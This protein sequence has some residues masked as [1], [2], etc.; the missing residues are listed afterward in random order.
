[1]K[2]IILAIIVFLGIYTSVNAQSYQPLCYAASINSASPIDV[3]TSDHLTLSFWAGNNGFLPMDKLLVN[4]RM[5]ITVSFL[6]LKPLDINDPAA[7][8]ILPPWLELIGYDDAINTFLFRQKATI[9]SF[10][11]FQIIMNMRIVTFSTP[12]KNSVNGMNVNIIPSPYTNQ[13]NLTGDDNTAEYGY[14]G[15]QT[16]LPVELVKF[17]GNLNQCNAALTWETASE[18]NNDYFSIE[19]SV[20]SIDWEEI[21]QVK[22]N[23]NSNSPISYS[24]TDEKLNGSLAYY[25]L[26]QYDYDGESDMSR[27]IAI[28]GKSCNS[29]AFKLYPNPTYDFINIELKER[30]KYKYVIYAS[31]GDIVK[32]SDL[33]KSTMKIFVGDLPAASYMITFSSED[34]Q[35]FHSFIVQK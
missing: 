34:K 9:G 27:V 13:Y 29:D 7:S 15:L 12:E 4:Q 28:D 25:R 26:V 5:R 22:G 19:K 11:V 6:G 23:G 35:I 20:N 16:I 14:T 1:M 18:L 10:E 31:N 21:G 33:T 3:S 2:N 32:Q 24:Y 17:E 8:M 30:E